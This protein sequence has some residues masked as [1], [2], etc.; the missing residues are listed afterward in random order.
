MRKIIFA[1]WLVVLCYT[2]QAQSDSIVWQTINASRGNFTFALPAQNQ[3]TIDSANE[4]VYFAMVDSAIGFSA[5]Y[6]TDFSFD[7]IP[8]YD[9]FTVHLSEG[10]SPLYAMASYMAFETNGT[11]VQSEVNTVTNHPEIKAVTVG[12]KYN[13]IDPSIFTYSFYKMYYWNNKLLTFSASAQ[14]DKLNDLIAAKTHFFNSVVI[15]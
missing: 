6:V 3:N 12:V 1:S 13:T 5:N 2:A 10:S 15:Q 14:D 11:M 4:L 9:S 8:D 7:S